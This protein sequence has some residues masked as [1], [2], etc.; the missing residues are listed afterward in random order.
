[1][2]EISAQYIDKLVDDRHYPLNH[3]TKKNIVWTSANGT[4]YEPED[5]ESSHLMNVI[6][7]CERRDGHKGVKFLNNAPSY[8]G[9]VDE[10]IKRGCLSNKYYLLELEERKNVRI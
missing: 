2:G 4:T 9:M 6:H 3:R 5:M 8:I 10:L 1:M 7:L